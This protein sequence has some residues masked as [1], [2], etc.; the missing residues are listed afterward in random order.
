MSGQVFPSVEALHVEACTDSS[1]Q[2]VTTLGGAYPVFE[3]LT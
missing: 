3:V 1:A 2:S